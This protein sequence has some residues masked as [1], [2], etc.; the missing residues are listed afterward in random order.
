MGARD[1]WMG[2]KGSGDVGSGPVTGG[3]KE[4]EKQRSRVLGGRK[5]ARLEDDRNL[6]IIIKKGGYRRP[7]KLWG[8]FFSGLFH[9]GKQH[10][11]P[12]TKCE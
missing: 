6:I 7:E 9:P 2:R 4:E 8:L 12:V 10:A 11:P 1:D 5:L 3:K